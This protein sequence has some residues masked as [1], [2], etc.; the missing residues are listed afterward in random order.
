MD[1]SSSFFFRLL[2]L[3]LSNSKIGR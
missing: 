1:I 2:K 3:G